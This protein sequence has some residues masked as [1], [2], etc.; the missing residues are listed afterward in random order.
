[1]QR[2]L[3]AAVAVIAVVLAAVLFVVL[4]PK[5][6]ANADALSGARFIVGNADAKVTLVEFSNFL[7]PYCERHANDLLPMI[8]KDY[9]DTGKVKYVFRDLQFGEGNIPSDVPIRAAEAAACVAD[10]GKYI[11]YYQALYRS[12]SQ[13]E[14]LT[15]A[16]LDKFLSDLAGQLGN[17][18][19]AVA[20]CLSA[21]KKRAGVDAD[22]ALAQKLQVNSTPTFF[23]NNKQVDNGDFNSNWR[24]LLDKAIAES[25]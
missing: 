25:Q 20:S 7:C 13:W 3:F 23:I 4:K 14:N 12:K 11:D 10:N 15:G 24:S 5:P 17:S 18:S 1:M 8:V 2:N 6:V 19:D 9:V 22:I 16:S 21:G